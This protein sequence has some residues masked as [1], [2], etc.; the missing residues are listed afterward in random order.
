MSLDATIARARELF[1]GLPGLAHRKMFGG[2][3]LYA[4]GRIFALIA[5]GE[6]YLKAKGAF[7]D[8]LAAEGSEPFVYDGRNRPVAMG[9]WRLPE[10][11][12]DAPDEALG[13]ARRALDESA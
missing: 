10:G 13:L 2:A 6:I 1:E 8:D 4:E 9:Y 5:D 11:A 7:A 12:H 3:G